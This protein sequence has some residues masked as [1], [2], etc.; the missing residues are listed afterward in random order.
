VRRR[1]PRL[2]CVSI[3]AIVFALIVLGA[4]I[5]LWPRALPS[6]E[7]LPAAVAPFGQGNPAVIVP[8]SSNPTRNSVR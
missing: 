4:A 8:A 3:A 6:A 2:G 7:A 5:L 1:L